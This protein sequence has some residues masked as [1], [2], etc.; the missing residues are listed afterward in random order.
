[1]GSQ[2]VRHDFATEQ[3]KENQ[4]LGIWE[5]SKFEYDKT[6]DSVFEKLYL[7]DSLISRDYRMNITG[8]NTHQDIYI[9]IYHDILEM[10]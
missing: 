6:S 10:I 8:L 7:K 4:Q 2:R 9:S 1:M 5:E 3:Q